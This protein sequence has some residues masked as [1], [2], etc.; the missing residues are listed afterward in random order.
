ME[1]YSDAISSSAVNG[2]YHAPAFFIPRRN[3]RDMFKILDMA[4]FT[5][6]AI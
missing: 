5:K 4:V 6:F 2:L 1:I 3:I